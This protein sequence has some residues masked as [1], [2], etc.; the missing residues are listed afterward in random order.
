LKE[1]LKHLETARWRTAVVVP[2]KQAKQKRKWLFKSKPALKKKMMAHLGGVCEDCGK[3]YAP[4]MMHF[5]HKRNK[6]FE[7]GE[8]AVYHTWNEIQEE[9][10]KCQLLCTECHFRKHRHISST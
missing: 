7:L 1:T 10:E 6:K 5:H 3:A 2:R 8:E 9:L 4:V